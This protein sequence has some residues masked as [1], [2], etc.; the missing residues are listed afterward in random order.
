MDTTSHGTFASDT[1]S[2]DELFAA[3]DRRE[4][5]RARRARN[6]RARSVGIGARPLQL[7]LDL[8]LRGAF[9]GPC[10]ADGISPVPGL[11]ARLGFPNRGW[12]G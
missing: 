2:A 1:A 7:R 10:S 4:I 12:Q 9:K 6:G 3:M 5:R 8:S 11:S